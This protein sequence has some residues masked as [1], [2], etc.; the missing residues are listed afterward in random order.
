MEEYDLRGMTDEE[1]N[2]AIWRKR[3]A[4]P[5]VDNAP[6]FAEVWRL[7]GDPDNM[8]TPEVV[9]CPGRRWRFDWSWAKDRLAV[10]VDGGQWLP[11]GGRHGGDKDR[12]K[13]NKAAALGWRVMHFSR[14]Q[15]VDDPLGVVE[16]VKEALGGYK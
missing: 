9:F 12:E 8:P 16:I 3:G 2:A 1:I 15:L 14:K 10:E 6:L 5:R 11:G 4:A 13:M 7:H